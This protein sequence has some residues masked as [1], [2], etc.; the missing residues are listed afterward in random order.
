MLFCSGHAA[1]CIAAGGILRLS[2]LG[3]A[4]LSFNVDT[5]PDA[6]DDAGVSIKNLSHLSSAAISC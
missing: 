3:Y 5:K 2:K 4:K 1:D 6:P